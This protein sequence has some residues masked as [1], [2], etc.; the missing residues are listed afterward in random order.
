MPAANR[1][2]VERALAW[3]FT[4]CLFLLSCVPFCSVR[5]LRVSLCGLTAATPRVR[6]RLK[7]I[8]EQNHTLSR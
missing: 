3:K 5:T 4:G 6:A 7:S 8:A 1:C 2:N